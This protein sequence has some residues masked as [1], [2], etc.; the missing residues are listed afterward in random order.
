MGRENKKESV[1]ALH[2]QRIMQAAE[3]LFAQR[4]FAETSIDALAQASGYSRRSLYAYC[5]S[6]EAL[7]LQMMAQGLTTVKDEIAAA[8]EAPDFIAQYHRAFQAMR[9]FLARCPAS[10][11]QINRARALPE[12]A[13]L[14]PSAQ[15]IYT[16]G[17]EINALLAG[18]IQQAQGA[19]QARAELLPILSA[20]LFWG[21][22]CSLF[23]LTQTK[24]DYLWR[25]AA[26]SEEEFW[27]YGFRQLM[28]AMLTR[29]M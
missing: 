3:A 8:G 23:A 14:S 19:G 1:A 12:D 20:Q 4:G 5:E 2:R 6:K 18:Y 10:A 21:G 24:G 11:E 17:A 7:L 16:L 13:A 27:E 22:V 9:A 29:P 26:L 28:N 15:A 25:A